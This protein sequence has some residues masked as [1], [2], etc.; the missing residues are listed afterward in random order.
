MGSF[1]TS[2][3]FLSGLA[4]SAGLTMLISLG[5]FAQGNQTQQSNPSTQGQGQPFP[6]GPRGERRR[7]GP[8]GPR[9]GGPGMMLR[10]FESLNLSDAQ[11]QQLKSIADQFQQTTGPKREEFRRL[12]ETRRNGGTLS[13]DDQ[14]KFDQLQTEFR[15]SMKKAHEDMLAVLTPEQRD[16][17]KQQRQERGE[18]RGRRQGGDAPQATQQ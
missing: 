17:L 7:G 9:G 12:A 6:G 11:K 13:A 3:R 1:M 2:R 18:R 16:Q 15:S 4:L 14:T 8:D 5:A 10:Q